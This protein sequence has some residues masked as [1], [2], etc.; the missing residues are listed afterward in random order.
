M[1]CN[2]LI[3]KIKFRVKLAT[4]DINDVSK[5]ILSIFPSLCSPSKKSELAKY[6]N[7]RTTFSWEFQYYVWNI[8]TYSP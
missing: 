2:E 6:R 7:R 8:L 1:C 3:I 5:S 4:E